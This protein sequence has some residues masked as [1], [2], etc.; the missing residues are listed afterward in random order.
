M[1]LE[2]KSYWVSSGN[3]SMVIEAFKNITDKEETLSLLQQNK[4]EFRLD[5]EINW[6]G[7]KSIDNNFLLNLLYLSGYLTLADDADQ[8]KDKPKDEPKEIQIWCFVIPNEE[9][10]G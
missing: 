10:R 8:P 6:E 1:S 2:F 7:M 9:V 4:I 3:P 5:V